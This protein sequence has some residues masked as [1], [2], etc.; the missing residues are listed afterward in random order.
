MLYFYMQFLVHTIEIFGISEERIL[1]FTNVI[2]LVV[3]T[4]LYLL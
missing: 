2:D 4:F 3:C 1:H